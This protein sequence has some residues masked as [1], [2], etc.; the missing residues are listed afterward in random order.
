MIKWL[1]MRRS[2]EWKTKRGDGTS[3]EVRVSFFGGK[4]TF[5]FKED[6]Q[7]E[8]DYSRKPS[9]EDLQDLWDAVQRRYQRR[10]ITDKELKEAR[11]ICSK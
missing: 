1:T 4:Y 3:Y 11:R 7:E 6:V 2:I 5:Q 8:W 9:L 10:Q